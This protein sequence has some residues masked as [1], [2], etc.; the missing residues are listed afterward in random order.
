M[1]FSAGAAL[2]PTQF[3][4]YSGNILQYDLKA[5]GITDYGELSWGGLGTCT[6]NKAELFVDGLPQVLARWPN[7]NSTTH[8][9]EWTQ[10]ASGSPSNSFFEYEGTEPARWV[11]ETDA[12]M[13]GYW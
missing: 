6:N 4:P 13:H 12:W 10:V 7:I 3:K 11:N 5:A 2:D 8:L 9:F 1:T